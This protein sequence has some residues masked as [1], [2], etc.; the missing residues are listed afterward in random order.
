MHGARFDTPALWLLGGGNFL[1]RSVMKFLPKFIKERMI[2][3]KVLGTG[4]N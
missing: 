3:E 2:R 4:V 1:T